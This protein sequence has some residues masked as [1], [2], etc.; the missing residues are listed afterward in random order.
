[1][2]L[3]KEGGTR[4]VKEGHILLFS[5]SL[6]YERAFCEMIP[7][8]EEKKRVVVIYMHAMF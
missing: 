2:E 1:M 3:R 7:M 8:F 4:V 6:C 5:L